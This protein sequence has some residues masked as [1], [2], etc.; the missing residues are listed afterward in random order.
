MR[1]MEEG[2]VQDPATRSHIEV[3]ERLEP[4]GFVGKIK[5]WWGNRRGRDVMEGSDAD[6]KQEQQEI[7]ELEVLPTPKSYYHATERDKFDVSAGVVSQEGVDNVTDFISWSMF[8]PYEKIGRQFNDG[9]DV[10]LMREDGKANFSVWMMDEKSPVLKLPD[11]RRRA[12][13]AREPVTVE[14]TDEMRDVGLHEGGKKMMIGPEHMV[15]EIPITREL[16]SLVTE[17]KVGI[18]TE[19]MS[20]EEL[21]RRFGE[22]FESCEDSNKVKMLREGLGQEEST[23]RLAHSLM[24]DYV[25]RYAPALRRMVEG[26]DEFS[27][28]EKNEIWKGMG[29]GIQS[30]SLRRYYG[31][32]TDNLVEG[33]LINGEVV[34]RSLDEGQLRK[35]LLELGE[36]NGGRGYFSCP[37][38][39][40]F[41]GYYFSSGELTFWAKRAGKEKLIYTPLVNDR[42]FKSLTIN[43]LVVL[44]DTYVPDSGLW[45]TRMLGGMDVDSWPMLQM[46]DG[47]PTNPLEAGRFREK[48]EAKEEESRQRFKKRFEKFKQ[49][50]SVGEDKFSRFD[51]LS[52]AQIETP[53]LFLAHPRMDYRDACSELYRVLTGNESSGDEQQDGELLVA[54]G[55]DVDP[56]SYGKMVLQGVYGE[57]D[58][59]WYR[60][61]SEGLREMRD[62]K[63]HPIHAEGVV[64]RKRDGE[65]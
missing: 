48:K 54:M 47:G 65:E 45:R 1:F 19:G 11:D 36:G 5:N 24:R 63:G 2:S 7:R 55:I 35:V 50:S 37:S 49:T 41:M 27:S 10:T 22:Y 33:G 16:Q 38:D 57:G 58:Q 6:Y 21:A 9:R 44:N 60:D 26:S 20:E 46:V 43:E 52:C 62:D 3:N 39:R 61:F 23:K 34:G 31:S 56:G 59:H 8:F 40:D 42:G 28:E 13:T 12:F 32:L 29:R 15:A 64:E 4:R 53:R 30:E 25:M 18:V 17:L 51:R 14:H